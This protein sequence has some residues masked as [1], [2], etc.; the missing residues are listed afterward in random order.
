MIHEYLIE[1][2]TESHGV[3][4]LDPD[5]NRQNLEHPEEEVP[6]FKDTIK[7]E[8]VQPEQCA[9]ANDAVLK[10]E[11]ENDIQIGDINT[12]LEEDLDMFMTAKGLTSFNE[13][14]LL[15]GSGKQLENGMNEIKVQVS[16]NSALAL[17]NYILRCIIIAL[18]E[19]LAEI[20]EVRHDFFSISC[21]CNYILAMAEKTRSNIHKSKNSI[22]KCT[23]ISTWSTLMLVY[24]LNKCQKFLMHY[25]SHVSA[26][27]I[28]SAL[29]VTP[30][31]VRKL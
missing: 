14:S 12:S 24:L 19:K 5:I 6:E 16:S 9:N 7:D 25:G 18:L 1:F 4:L 8:E 30:C 21:D 17:T 29:E 27:F 23:A 13:T 3:S 11:V 22:E 26:L 20:N 28:A 2:D 10:S 31:F 15:K